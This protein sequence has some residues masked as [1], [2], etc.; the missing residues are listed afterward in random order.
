MIA[1]VTKVGVVSNRVII[2]RYFIDLNTGVPSLGILRDLSLA[3]WASP[4]LAGTRDG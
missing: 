1:W 4:S 2:I 3:L